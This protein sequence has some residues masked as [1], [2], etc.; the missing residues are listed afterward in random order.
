M[1]A[2]QL[3]ADRN[4]AQWKDGAEL[5]SVA[6]VDQGTLTTDTIRAVVR[7]RVDGGTVIEQV[8]DATTGTAQITVEYVINSSQ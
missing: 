2:A 6:I 5:E 1:R 4:F 8:Y 7:A 3:V